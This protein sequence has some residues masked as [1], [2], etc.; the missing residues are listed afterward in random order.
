MLSCTSKPYFG[1]VVAPFDYHGPV[2]AYNL[3]TFHQGRAFDCRLPSQMNQLEKKFIT[4][5]LS[6]LTGYKTLLLNSEINIF[7]SAEEL[8]NLDLIG[9]EIDYSRD[10][11]IKKDQLFRVLASLN[12]TNTA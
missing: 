4:L 6:A 3:S 9:L 2:H 8:E 11:L 7:F 10:I 12:W 1:V 5:G